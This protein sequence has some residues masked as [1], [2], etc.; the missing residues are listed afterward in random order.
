VLPTDEALLKTATKPTE[1]EKSTDK[2]LEK[3]IDQGLVL[4]LHTHYL[5]MTKSELKRNGITGCRLK[6]ALMLMHKMYDSI[7]LTI[8]I[9]FAISTLLYLFFEDFS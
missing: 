5:H 3:S 2:S 8:T 1:T 9:F 7:Y 4:S 6:M